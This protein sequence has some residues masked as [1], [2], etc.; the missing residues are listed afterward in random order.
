MGRTRRTRDRPHENTRGA[1]SEADSGVGRVETLQAALPLDDPDLL[2]PVPLSILHVL[3][4]QYPCR[5]PTKLGGII[6][7]RGYS[8]G[9]MKTKRSG[10]PGGQ[11]YTLP[12]RWQIEP[13]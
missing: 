10:G 6:L 1:D 3:V 2:L 12:E 9:V 5:S 11:I 8:C 4:L 7:Y 13:R